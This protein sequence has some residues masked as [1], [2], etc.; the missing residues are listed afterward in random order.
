[1]MGDEKKMELAKQIYQKLC[2]TIEKREWD[3]RRDDEKLLVHFAV[4]NKDIPMRLFLIVDAK[5]QLISVMSPLPFKMS[6]SNRLEGAIAA[7]AASF[8]MA[9][10]SFDYDISDGTIAFRMTAYFRDSLIGEGLFLYLIFWSCEMVNKYNDL[11]FA[12][13]KGIMS[14]ADFIE[15]V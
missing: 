6:E 2:E 4:N 7:C 12:L 13:D 8:G 9:D 10:G 5:N 3:F 11:F 1:M 14:I 15:K